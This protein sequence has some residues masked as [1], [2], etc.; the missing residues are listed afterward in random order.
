M[1]T[2]LVTACIVLACAVVYLF[3]A[4]VALRNDVETL[5]TREELARQKAS[6]AGFLVEYEGIAEKV[7]R[8]LKRLGARM[9][10]SLEAG[11]FARGQTWEDEPALNFDL[12][13]K[14]SAED[15]RRLKEREA[16]G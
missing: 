16:R 14:P 9:A 15:F 3:R 10:R 8:N 13:D 5:P 1:Q 7:D 6:W 11:E 4:L 2:F 12:I